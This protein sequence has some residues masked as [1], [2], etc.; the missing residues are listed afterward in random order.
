MRSDHFDKSHDLPNKRI[1]ILMIIR[2][3]HP[4]LEKISHRNGVKFLIEITVLDMS[5]DQEIESHNF[6]DV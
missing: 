4:P 6:R 3:L 5:S 1:T 2:M